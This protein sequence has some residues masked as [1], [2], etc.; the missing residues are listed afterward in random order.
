[1]SKTAK[2]ISLITSIQTLSTQKPSDQAS[3]PHLHTPTSPSDSPRTRPSTPLPHLPF[4]G[5]INH[6]NCQPSG[7]AINRSKPYCIKGS[8]ILCT[9]KRTSKSRCL[10]PLNGSKEDAIKRSNRSHRHIIGPP[11]ILTCR[12]RVVEATTRWNSVFDARLR[13]AEVKLEV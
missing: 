13:S 5:F 12:I 6:V 1:M 7:K 10:I 4:T 9:A 2:N 3:S 11:T 8:K